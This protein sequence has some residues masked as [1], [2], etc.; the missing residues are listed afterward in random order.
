MAYQFFNTAQI[1][2]DDVAGL[3]AKGSFKGQLA[4]V[5]ATDELYAWDGAAWD[6]IGPGSG[7]SGA[8]TTADYLVKTADAGLSAERVVT[9]TATITWDWA[10]PGQAKANFI[11]GSGGAAF[12][13]LMLIGA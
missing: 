9:D 3:P 6:L 1:L 12:S 8:P 10:T 5:D 13:E 2:S 11:G 7:G 4:Y